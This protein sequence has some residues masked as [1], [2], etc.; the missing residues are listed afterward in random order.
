VTEHTIKI[1]KRPNGDPK[2]YWYD[3]VDGH[4]FHQ[5]DDGSLHCFNLYCEHEV[6]PVWQ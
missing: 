5:R 1:P 6:D 4:V 2:R 3:P